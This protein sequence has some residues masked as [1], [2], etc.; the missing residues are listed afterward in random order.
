MSEENWFKKALPWVDFLKIRGSFGLTGRDNITPWQWTRLYNS[1]Q[2]G[3]PVFGESAE[4]APGGVITTDKTRQR[5]ILTFTGIKC[6][7]PTLVS[8][9][10]Y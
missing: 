2:W 5:S 4:R 10:T 9:L 3:G 6:T 8:T 1:N 7:R